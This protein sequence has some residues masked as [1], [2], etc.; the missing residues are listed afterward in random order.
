MSRSRPRRG[1]RVRYAND[2]SDS[3]DFSEFETR[4]QPSRA[5]RRV[6][7]YRESS[8]EEIQQSSEEVLDSSSEESP[9][10]RMARMRGSTQ[11]AMSSNTRKRKAPPTTRP[12]TA[13]AFTAYKRQKIRPS[14][15]P[16]KPGLNATIITP[17]HSPKGQIPPWQ[18]LPYH[19]L[20][21][22]MKYAAYPLYEQASR[23]TPSI[24]WLCSVSVLCRSLHDACMAALLYSPPL[25]P[26]WRAHGLI[27]LLTADPAGL[28]TDYRKKIHHVDIEVKQLLVKKSGISVDN[29][30]SR[31]PLLQSMRLYSNHDDFRTSIWAQPTAQRFNWSYPAELFD[32][33]D[34]NSLV[35]KS[36]EWNGRFSNAIGALQTAFSAHCRP[37]FR[38]LREVSLLNMT[39]PEKSTE[40]D[41]AKAQSLLGG[42]LKELSGLESLSFRNCAILDE[43]TAAMLPTG[44]QHLEVAHCSRLTSTALEQY[45]LTGGSTLTT[46]RLFG[47]QSMSLGFMANLQSLCPRL[48]N[49]EVDMIYIDPTSYRDRDPLYDELLPN[50]P[51]TWPTNL[52][53]VSV[54]NLRQLSAADAEEFFASL[55]DC[56]ENLPSLKKLNIKAIL[57][58]ASWRDRAKLR[59]T[60]LPKL[61]NVFLNTAEPTNA[62]NRPSKRSSQPSQRQSTR[63]AN[64]HLKKLSLGDV[65]DESE[66]PM[67]KTTQA[68]CDVV[69]L[70]ISDQRP[71]QEQ[72]HED[73]FLDDEPSD[74]GDWNGRDSQPVS[75]GYAW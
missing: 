30:I 40:L 12:S 65:T 7:T 13:N 68:R 29:L 28:M 24:N 50:G 62:S 5:V 34:S 3:D 39:L 25:Y 35:M 45:L 10:Q 27:R 71:S 70:V 23:N 9:P 51:P 73:D 58:D 55:V 22:I 48:Q 49:L 60:W 31:T 63:I 1:P 11:D 14:D 18:Q 6:Q 52:V 69:N 2:D 32:R 47:N 61:E 36:F 44:L 75:T 20:V 56:S 43:A 59:K 17:W 74:D 53:N 41:V 37:A 54:E 46:L 64:S 4:S 19:I 42:A 67:P 66:V 26:A 33:L 72:F 38:R 16:S 57:K 15:L 8:D 21:N